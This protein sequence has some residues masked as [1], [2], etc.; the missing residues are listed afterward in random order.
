MREA[1]AETETYSLGQRPASVT[2]QS[3]CCSVMA[4][5]NFAGGSLTQLLFITGDIY[6]SYHII[7]SPHLPLTSPTSPLHRN[8]LP[9]NIG[10]I[11]QNQGMQRKISFKT[12]SH[13]KAS[14]QYIF[15][16]NSR[17][18][19]LDSSEFSKGHQVVESPQKDKNPL[20]AIYP[21]PPLYGLSPGF[22]RW[23]YNEYTS[24]IEKW[25]WLSQVTWQKSQSYF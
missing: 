21:H 3:C 23:K 1:E 22:C 7:L 8:C 5:Y 4:L 6:T 24:L 10:L 12:H 16:A 2:P 25:L 11:D 15:Q 17:D 9:I 18:L 14:I 19:V 13:S 20:D